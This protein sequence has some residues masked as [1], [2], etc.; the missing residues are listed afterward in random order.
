MND[1]TDIDGHILKEWNSIEDYHQEM[2]NNFNKDI[3]ISY[4]A[5]GDEWYETDEDLITGTIKFK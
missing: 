2:D 3:K 5:L 1:N 4:L